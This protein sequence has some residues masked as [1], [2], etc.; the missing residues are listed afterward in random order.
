MFS[1][2]LRVKGRN[3]CFSY[4]SRE[5]SML[6]Q[7]RIDDAWL[8]G[9][10]GL[11]AE[12]QGMP[13]P[14]PALAFYITPSCSQS[15]W[16]TS[17][18]YSKLVFKPCISTE[19]PILIQGEV[20]M[21]CLQLYDKASGSYDSVASKNNMFYSVSLLLKCQ[22]EFLKKV[23]VDMYMCVCVCIYVFINK[24]VWVTSLSSPTHVCSTQTAVLESQNNSQ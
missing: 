14:G 4:L 9:G 22:L 11:T 6:L 19:G 21:A 18:V 24:C 17:F 5:E 15:W 8:M 3:K 13:P 7:W 10:A 16:R 23:G 1:R 12:S 2:W 20:K